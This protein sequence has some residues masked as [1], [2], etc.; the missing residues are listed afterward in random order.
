MKGRITRDEKG[1]VL[2]GG[3]RVTNWVKSD[4]LTT[5]DCC[6]GY[7]PNNRYFSNGEVHRVEV[8]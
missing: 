5:C 7:S 8:E 2:V 3:V 1:K 4:W 6:E